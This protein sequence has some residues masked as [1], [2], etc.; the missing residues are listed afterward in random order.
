MPIKER[1]PY[2]RQ[3]GNTTESKAAEAAEIQNFLKKGNVERVPD[4]R[5]FDRLRAAKRRL[6]VIDL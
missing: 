2:A 3:L 5:F 4:N 6:N 1:D